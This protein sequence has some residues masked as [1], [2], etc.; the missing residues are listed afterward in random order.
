MFGGKTV[1]EKIEM[2]EFTNIFASHLLAQNIQWLSKPE[3]LALKEVILCQSP[4]H[5][6]VEAQE[7]EE[8]QAFATSVNVAQ[9]PNKSIFFC[10]C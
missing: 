2:S 7:N 6:C 8:N 5:W 10:S 3:Y 1:Y 4:N 9:Y